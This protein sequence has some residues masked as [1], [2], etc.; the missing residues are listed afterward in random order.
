MADKAIIYR[1]GNA[2]EGQESRILSPQKHSNL[3]VFAAYLVPLKN[4]I[5]G[6]LNPFRM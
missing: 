4:T 2:E 5:T 6:A 3:M 1:L